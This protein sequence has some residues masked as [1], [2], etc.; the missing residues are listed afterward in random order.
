MPPRRQ[1]RPPVVGDFRSSTTATATFH[2][3]AN[4]D[5]LE[6]PTSPGNPELTYLDQAEQE[7]T[8]T[9]NYQYKMVN[10][11]IDL[12][13]KIKSEAQTAFPKVHAKNLNGETRVTSM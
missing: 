11:S 5:A 8:D 10:E 9:L 2:I 12:P 6:G 1:G 13:I 4:Q 7:G 3:K